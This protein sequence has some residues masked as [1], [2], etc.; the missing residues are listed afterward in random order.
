MSEAYTVMSKVGPLF[1]LTS[2]GTMA[3]I[4]M[5]SYERPAD[6]LWDAIA[7]TLHEKGWTEGQ[8]AVWLR[9]K[10]PRYALD[11]DLGDAIIALGTAYAD[12]LVPMP[13]EPPP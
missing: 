7:K 2:T 3:E 9:S 4:P 11:G 12:K 1:P 5:Y 10:M 6:M 13:E 8:I